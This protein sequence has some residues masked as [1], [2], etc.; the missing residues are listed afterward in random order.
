M[1]LILFPGD[2][3][4]TS[5]DSSWSCTG[6]DAFRRRLAE[7]EGFAAATTSRL[8]SARRSCPA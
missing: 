8:P 7:A 3:D 1:G 6:F 5:P 4:T 2:G